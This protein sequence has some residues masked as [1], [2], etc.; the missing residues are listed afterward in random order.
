MDKSKVARRI[1]F[2]ENNSGVN[3]NATVIGTLIAKGRDESIV[4]RTFD[5]V[6]DLL[7]ID[8]QVPD[9]VN[10]HVNPGED[11]FDADEEELDYE[12]D[13]P[14]G[15]SGDS[16]A[17]LELLC[18]GT[19][20]SKGKR[21]EKGTTATDEEKFLDQNPQ[22]QKLFDHY[23]SK[24]LETVCGEKEKNMI[25]ILKTAGSGKNKSNKVQRNLVRDNQMI[26]S[27]SDTTIY[28]PALKRP[29]DKEI[30]VS[31]EARENWLI[32][33]ELVEEKVPKK[34]NKSDSIIEKISRFVESIRMDQQTED[35]EENQQREHPQAGPSTS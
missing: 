26:K 15:D 25:K 11:D 33:N 5:E 28:M 3:N 17:G 30:A 22:L 8:K 10:V 7:N 20:G 31:N 16:N 34:Q 1:N 35:E 27:P 14:D 6:N 23:L 9:G 12:D 4:D 19:S 32:D 24:K 21:K 13:V 2:E 29:L 18:V